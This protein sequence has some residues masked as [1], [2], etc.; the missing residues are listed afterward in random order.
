MRNTIAF[1]VYGTLIDPLAIGTD[2]GS[3]IGDRAPLFAAQWRDRQ[4]EY[5]FRRGLMGVYEDFSE[6]TR[7][8]LEHT[9]AVFDVDLQSDDR[10]AL[11]A[12]YRNLPAYPDVPA[13]LAR[14]REQGHAMHAFSNGLPS[15]LSELLNHA[16]IA[17]LLDGVVSV[18]PVR[19]FKPDP[20]VYRHFVAR[21]G[22]PIDSL[23]LASS[24]PF[25]VIGARAV[26]WQAAWVRR[27]PEAVFDPWEFQPSVTL[28]TLAGLV[29][30]IG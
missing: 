10:S 22:A 18:H 13:A 2:L 29:E 30:A 12:R 24:N 26:G 20:A 9:C 28:A 25:D 5:S 8:A 23:W 7:R 6:C 3:L 1:D 17:D 21:T 16:G 4:L 15:D 19:S 27:R 11:L 14:L